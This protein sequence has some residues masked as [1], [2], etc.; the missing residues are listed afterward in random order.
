MFDVIDV[1]WCFYLSTVHSN[2]IAL[3]WFD[4][5]ENVVPMQANADW[6][7]ISPGGYSAR[8]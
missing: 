4:E 8:Q 3:L 5:K 1:L 2:F 7:E 6:S